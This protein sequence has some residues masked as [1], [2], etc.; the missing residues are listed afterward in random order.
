MNVLEQAILKQV[1]HSSKSLIGDT[2][3][4]CTVMY[5]FHGGTILNSIKMCSIIDL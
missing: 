2:I 4:E 5:F 1:L 3:H